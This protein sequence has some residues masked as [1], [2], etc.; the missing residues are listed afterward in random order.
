MKIEKRCLS[1]PLTAQLEI[2]DFC[3]HKCLHYYNFDSK[4]ENRPTR[5]VKDEIIM[6]SARKL[7]DNGIFSVI[8]TGGEPLIKKDLT[9][10][11][12]NIKR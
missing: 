9:K 11:V 8:I 2:T 12:M 5:I 3:N 1:L 6:A 10:R 7:V 4:I